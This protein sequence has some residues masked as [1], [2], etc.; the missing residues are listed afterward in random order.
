MKVKTSMPTI[1]RYYLKGFLKLFLIIGIG[2][3]F[4]LSILELLEKLDELIRH[5]VSASDIALYAFYG[6][7]K[8]L[9]YLM[10]LSALLSSLFILGQASRRKEIV[11]VM[12]SGG[13]LKKLLLPFIF[14][15]VLLSLIGF[16]LSEFI[17]PASLKKAKDIKVSKAKTLQPLFKE[18]TVW[19]RGEDGSIVRMNLYLPERELTKGISIFKIKEGSLKQRI[20]AEEAIYESGSW[21]LK[22]VRVFDISDASTRRISS[23]RYPYLESP[24]SLMKEI[25][26]PEEMAIVEHIRYVRKL[27][28]A[29]IKN[30][31]L[32]VDMNSKLSYPLINLF[33]LVIGISFSVRR[34][35]HGLLSSAIGVL[36]SLLYWFGFTMALSLGY[37]GIL[38]AFV[39]AWS[40]PFIFSIAS[41][42]LFMTIPE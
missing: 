20:E 2:L 28:A 9:S 42:Y 34:G 4:I 5:A 37:A 27:N 38:P 11:A 41:V 13:R 19:L 16:G 21:I 25:K 8:Y 30:T 29:G 1:T 40:M 18:G 33:M 24:K 7:P 31:K 6:F 3:S 36:I 14:V 12:A 39:S 17:V 32:T 22:D 26:K 15:G 23:M 35:L 10:P